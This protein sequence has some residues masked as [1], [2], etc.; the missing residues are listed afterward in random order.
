[1]SR[2]KINFKSLLCLRDCQLTLSRIC[3]LRRHPRSSPYPKPYTQTLRVHLAFLLFVCLRDCQLRYTTLSSSKFALPKAFQTIRFGIA[4]SLRS[5]SSSQFALPK[6]LQPNA[7]RSV[8]FFAFRLFTKV[9]FRHSLKPKK[10]VTYVTG[11]VARPGF[12]P[13]TSEL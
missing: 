8:G 6:A 2:V 12:E 11:F 1:M 10:P 7:S 13:G 3:R 9:N 4:S 5:L